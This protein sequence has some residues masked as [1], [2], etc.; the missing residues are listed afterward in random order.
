MR[1]HIVLLVGLNCLIKEPTIEPLMEKSNVDHH[2]RKP[3]CILPKN[4][5]LDQFDLCR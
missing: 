3:F 1:F 4:E 2:K 5:Q